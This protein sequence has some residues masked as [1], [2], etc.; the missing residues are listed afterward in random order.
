MN[1]TRGLF[2]LWVVL[3]GLWI[4]AVGVF[5]FEGIANPYFEPRGFYF[6]KDV[7]KA[8]A[9]AQAGRRITMT[10]DSWSNFE[11]SMPAGFVYEMHGTGGEDAYNRLVA[12]LESAPYLDNP[13]VVERYT[14]AYRALEE[15]VSRKASQRISIHDLPG[16]SLFVEINTTTAEKERQVNATHAFAKQLRDTGVGKKRSNALQN[17][18]VAAIAPPLILLALGWLVIWIVR[19]FKRDPTANVK[20]GQEAMRERAAVEADNQLRRVREGE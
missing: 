16:V 14:D 12:A 17:T 19:G 9:Q 20:A 4:I 1:L 5:S 8:D 6:R 3:T 7:S 15:G 18:A 10:P 13:E 2:R 11:I